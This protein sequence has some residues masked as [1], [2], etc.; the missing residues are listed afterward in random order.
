M[1]EIHG[2]QVPQALDDICQ[3]KHMALIVYDMQVGIVRQL[4]D[5]DGHGLAARQ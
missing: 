4:K 2:L 1:Q 3:P 5:P